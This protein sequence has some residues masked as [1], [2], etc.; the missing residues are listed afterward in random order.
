MPDLEFAA[1]RILHAFGG[2]TLETLFAEPLEIFLQLA[3]LADRVLAHR[4]LEYPV[5]ALNAPLQQNDSILENMR[6]RRGNSFR[7]RPDAQPVSA[8]NLKA[9]V[10]L[11]RRISSGQTAVN[12]VRD[13]TPGQM[14]HPNAKG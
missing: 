14:T 8:E 1:A 12:N 5:I 13:Y 7:R 3:A 9:A 4:T 10:E 2:Y 11:A 6:R